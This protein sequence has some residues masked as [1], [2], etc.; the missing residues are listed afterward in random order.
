MLTL[1]LPCRSCLALA[2]GPYLAVLPLQSFQ[3]AV[4]TAEVRRHHRHQRVHLQ[5]RGTSDLTCLAWF[6]SLR[7]APA[8]VGLSNAPPQLP[9]PQ[10]QLHRQQW[11]RWQPGA[12]DGPPEA[13]GWGC[14]KGMDAGGGGSFSKAAEEGR[15]PAADG[16]LRGAAAGDSSASPAPPAS[17]SVPSAA[18]GDTA[19]T[20]AAA[21][22]DLLES[23]CLLSGTAD[24]FVQIHDRGGRVLFRQRLHTSAVVHIAVRP[25]A[26]GERGGVGC[27]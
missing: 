3:G 13:P 2:R 25:C 14:S 16:D 27:T 19:S 11:R 17:A 18:A 15:A 8:N 26:A 12:A 9:P 6:V 7:Q 24:G 5:P 20:A 21:A 1:P 10:P 23:D 22:L 4:T